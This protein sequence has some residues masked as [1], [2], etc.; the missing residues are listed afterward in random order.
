MTR[1]LTATIIGTNIGCTL[2]VRALRGAG[3]TVQSLVGRDPEQTAARARHFGIPQALTSLEEAIDSDVDAVIV[4][5]P[6]VTHHP[7]AM[8]AIAAGKHVL[9][10]KPLAIDIGHAREMRDAAHEAGLVHAVSHE[11]RW[12]ARNALTR[13]LVAEGRIGR[14]VHVQA[15]FNAGLCAEPEPQ[16]PAWW[17]SAAEGGGWLRNYNAHGIDVIRYAL[18]EFGAV[19]GGTRVGA[20][21]GMDADDGYSFAFAMANGSQGVMSGSTRDHG[22]LDVLRIAGADAT[23]VSTT[24]GY[25][26]LSVI[27]HTGAHE[28]E[29]P[30][31]LAEQLLGTGPRVSAPAEPLHPIGETFYERS[32]ASDIG[33]PEQV[34][35]SAAFAAKIRDRGYANP[36]MALFDDGVAHM[37]VIEAVER[38]RQT[39]RWIDLA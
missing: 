27:D 39:G 18:G 13:R 26:P 21:R 16:I 12:F 2:H 15:L 23:I 7:F 4:A 10:E 37:A 35:L 11:F 30:A 3:F 33:Y 29:V 36:A 28:P 17:R 22:F 5:T 1:P 25:A 6:P 24:V 34:A 20:D 8:K 38:S 32:H 31:D 19:A 9:C 14:P